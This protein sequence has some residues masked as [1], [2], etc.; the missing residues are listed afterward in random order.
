M[1]IK[2]GWKK[3]W[4]ELKEIYLKS[5]VFYLYKVVKPKDL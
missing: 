5:N 2:R 3:V 1:I 4:I